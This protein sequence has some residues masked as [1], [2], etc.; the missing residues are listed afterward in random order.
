MAASDEDKSK[1][2][3]IITDCNV[4]GVKDIDTCA[5]A[6]RLFACYKKSGVTAI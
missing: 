5:K 2:E 4:A 1:I 6:F 3:K